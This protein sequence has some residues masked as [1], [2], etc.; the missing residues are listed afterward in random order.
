[1][2]VIT[3]ASSPS[4][5]LI[6]L[7]TTTSASTPRATPT[8]ETQAIKEMK[9][10]DDFERRKRPARRFTAET[11]LLRIPLRPHER[12]QDHV[13]DAGRIREEHHQ[14]VDPDPLP[15]G[16]RHAVLES[17]DVVLVHIGGF[18]VARVLGV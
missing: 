11:R 10:S 4:K 3:R 12:E 17:G 18:F 16:R 14:A 13:P 8:T 5:P 7:V 15:R 6:T 1:M 2:P 9:P